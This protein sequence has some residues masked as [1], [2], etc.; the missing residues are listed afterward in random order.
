L[1]RRTYDGTSRRLAAQATRHAILGAARQLFVQVGYVGT[2]MPAIAQAAG[3]ALDTVYASVGRKPALFRLLIETSISGSDEA[4]SA[5]ERGYVVA[6][7]AEP[8]ARKKL[9]IYAAA[10][11]RIHARLAPLFKVLQ[12]ASSADADLAEL[13]REVSQ[14][15]AS[16]MRLFAADLAA[17]GGLRK[18]LGQ[19]QAADIIWSMNS[20][21]FYL[22]LVEQ[23]GWSPRAFES[24]LAD[25][26]QRLLLSAP[27]R[28]R[29]SD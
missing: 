4:Q 17:T 21:E 24:W 5:E 1:K 13:W 26:W 14:R 23:R 28:S 15:R 27:R 6:I 25:A 10:L 11:T 29:R 22:L 12:G 3:V 18:N 7:R 19:D 8:K 20:P 9:E 2:T 16:N